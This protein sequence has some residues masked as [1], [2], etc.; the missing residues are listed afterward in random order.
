MLHLT[1]I[2]APPVENTDLFGLHRGYLFDWDE[3]LSA[4]AQA[5]GEALADQGLDSRQ[6]PERPPWAQSGPGR[7][8]ASYVRSPPE[9]DRED[10]PF[11][12]W[13]HCK[14]GVEQAVT[15][16]SLP[17]GL[18]EDYGQP[19]SGEIHGYLRNPVK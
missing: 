12:P 14:R 15:Q 2:D 19:R 9:L 4:H 7:D 10:P 8:S 17:K 18:G 6:P 16:K 3:D 5:F 11:W 1:T 13:R